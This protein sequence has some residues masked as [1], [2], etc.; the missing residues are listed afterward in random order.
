[1]NGDLMQYSKRLIGKLRE[2]L[3][4]APSGKKGD[5]K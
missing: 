2:L 3:G 1:M 5:G 4:N